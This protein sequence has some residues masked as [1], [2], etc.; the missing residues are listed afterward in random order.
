MCQSEAL[1]TNV[2]LKCACHCHRWD[3]HT[4]VTFRHIIIK[5]QQLQDSKARENVYYR[6][7]KFNHFGKGNVF[8]LD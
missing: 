4:T 2:L 5:L 7:P 6:E 1:T 3:Q 8:P